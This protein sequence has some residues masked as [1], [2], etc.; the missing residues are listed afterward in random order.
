MLYSGAS[1]IRMNGQQQERLEKL[2]INTEPVQATQAPEDP[3]T[4]LDQET[5]GALLRF[6][7]FI[8]DEKG[9]KK[10]QNEK[11]NP[12]QQKKSPV[13]AYERAFAAETRHD[14]CGVMLNI[15]A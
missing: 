15:Y 12:P 6:A 2:K 1:L 3:G 7:R 5:H 14:N 11:K 10:S 9:K 8:N 13:E 4:Q